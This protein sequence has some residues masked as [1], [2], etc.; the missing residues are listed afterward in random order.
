ML[1]LVKF[2]EEK[3]AYNQE[4]AM[5]IIIMRMYGLY[6]EEKPEYKG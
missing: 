6:A 4:T 3:T 1:S 5:D 2:W